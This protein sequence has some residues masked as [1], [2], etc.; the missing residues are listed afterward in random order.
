MISDFTCLSFLA[1]RRT[2]DTIATFDHISLEADRSR[3][4]VQLEEEA[5]GIAEDGANLIPPPQRCGRRLAI[6]AYRLQIDIVMISKGCHA[7][8]RD[9][10]RGL[11]ER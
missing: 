4:A 9:N 8:G 6:L 10:V 1:L 11:A 5:A 3:T 2:F 7:F